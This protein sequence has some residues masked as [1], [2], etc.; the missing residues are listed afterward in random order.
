M[1]KRHR[2]KN[3]QR[4]HQKK[5]AALPLLPPE[6]LAPPKTKSVLPQPQQSY[7]DPVAEDSD[8]MSENESNSLVGFSISSDSSA[9]QDMVTDDPSDYNGHKRKRADTNPDELAPA[10]NRSHNSPLPQSIP[11]NQLGITLG[12]FSPT[13]ADSDYPLTRLQLEPNM[14]TPSPQRSADASTPRTPDQRTNPPTREDNTNLTTIQEV[15]DI[16]V[17]GFLGDNPLIGIETKSIIS[18]KKI[19]GFKALV[20]PHDSSFEETTKVKTGKQLELAIASHLKKTGHVVT[21]PK[22]AEGVEDRRPINRRPWV[23]LISQ[24][25]EKDLDKI[26]NDEFITN[27]HAS[28]HIIPFSPDPSHYIGRIKNL[29]IDP[30]LHQTVVKLIQRTISEDSVT[31]DFI[32]NFVTTYHDTI[33]PLILKSGTAINWIINSVK[34]YHIQSEGRLGMEHSQWKWYI[35]T[36][37]RIQERVEQWTRTLAKISFDA[38]I[39]GVGDTLTNIKCARCKST[40]HSDNE[41]PFTQHSDFIVPKTTAEP[42]NPRGGRG[43]RRSNPNRGNSGRGNNRGRN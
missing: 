27:E 19:P 40:N 28:L 36:P 16:K 43:G 38:T 18:W 39:Y 33:P 7:R 21:A 30:N 17:T 11:Q 3:R 8:E 23:F 10:S 13:I 37:T 22:P 41:C 24:L 31:T 5:L 29:T 14:S 1:A 35:F 32:V 34:A 26:L 25:T 12:D 4:K 20:Y 15:K 9:N 6:T 2:E 42:S